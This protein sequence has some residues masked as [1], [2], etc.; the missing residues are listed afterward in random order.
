MG[1][2]ASSPTALP[3]IASNAAPADR[4]AHTLGSRVSCPGGRPGVPDTAPWRLAAVK[5]LR[6]VSRRFIVTESLTLSMPLF[7]HR[8]PRG[9]AKGP[10]RGAVTYTR[11]AATPNA[12]RPSCLRDAEIGRTQQ[13]RAKTSA[14]PTNWTLTRCEWRSVAGPPGPSPVV[15]TVVGGGARAAGLAWGPAFIMHEFTCSFA[16]SQQA[17]GGP[18][19]AA[20]T[21]PE[22]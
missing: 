1:P 20:G 4:P 13:H 16:D 2:A 7:A 11:L 22:R 19:T 6:C 8:E 9:R 17:E 12:G 21:R 3:A 10:D 18:A 14:S 5:T 15:V